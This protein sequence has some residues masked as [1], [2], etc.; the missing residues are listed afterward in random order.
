MNLNTDVNDAR[1]P[2]AS[3]NGGLLVSLV[4]ICNL[5]TLAALHVR[6]N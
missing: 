1:Q 6:V 3:Y 2:T 4:E 5:L